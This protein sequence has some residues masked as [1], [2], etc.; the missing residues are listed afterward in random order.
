MNI[1]WYPG[2]MAKAKKEI[3]GNLK[4]VDA[5]IE[6]TDARAPKSSRNPDIDAILKQK[7]KIIVLNKCELANSNATEKWI[8]YYKSINVTA[9]DVDSMTGKNINKVQSIIKNI[10]SDRMLKY[11]NKGV[12]NR[13]IKVMVVGIPNVGKSAFIN[14][15]SKKSNAKVGNKPGFTKS[16][17]WIQINN[18]FFIMDTPG[19]LWP[20]IE[21]NKDA[22]HLAYIYS[23]DDKILDINE[24]VLSFI[25]EIKNIDNTILNKRYRIDDYDNPLDVLSAIAKKEAACLA[26][27]T[28]ILTDVQN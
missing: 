26:V 15:I 23:I 19:V 3:E 14:K 1:Q 21:D 11:K 12:I 7:P 22:A 4:L 16:K 20:K 28:L 5:V 13:A 8:K 27:E 9:I 10:I 18:S 17:Q 6:L 2:H 24:L 25:K